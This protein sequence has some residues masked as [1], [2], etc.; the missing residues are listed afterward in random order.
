MR[1]WGDPVS[2][3]EVCDAAPA[4]PSAAGR[5]RRAAPRALFALVGCWWW[6]WGGLVLWCGSKCV[7]LRSML[8]NHVETARSSPKRRTGRSVGCRE[9]RIFRLTQRPAAVPYAPPTRN[10]SPMLT[11]TPEDSKDRRTSTHTASYYE[12]QAYAISTDAW[13]RGPSSTAGEICCGKRCLTRGGDP[14]VAT[15]RPWATLPHRPSRGDPDLDRGRPCH[16]RRPSRGDPVLRRPQHAAG[17]RP[18]PPLR[19]GCLAG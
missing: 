7:L 8:Q 4:R 16:L 3:Q 12:P 15:A 5:A 10:I 11:V 17:P 6:P 1:W 13:T 2:I 19:P 9:R 18:P 14:V